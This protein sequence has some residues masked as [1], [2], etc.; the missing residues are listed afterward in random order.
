MDTKT[1]QILIDKFRLNGFVEGIDFVTDTR[2]IIKSLKM[3]FYFQAQK[4]A[5]NINEIS[6]YAGKHKNFSL[7]QTI[8]CE[9]IGIRLIQVWDSC[10]SDLD[11]LFHVLRVVLRE[12]PQPNKYKLKSES[13]S[14][15][16]NSSQ[17]N[18]FTEEGWSLVRVSEPEF[19]WVTDGKITE[20]RQMGSRKL[21]DCGDLH[22]ILKKKGSMSRESSQ[23]VLDMRYRL[24]QWDAATRGLSQP[25]ETYDITMTQPTSGSFLT[26]TYYHDMT[27]STTSFYSVGMSQEQFNDA[28][29]TLISVTLIS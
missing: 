13:L 25:A 14:R 16:W 17:K 22:Y 29:A 11:R 21:Y 19:V 18:Y 3:D 6:I 1:Q 15:M 5:I 10:F 26:Y 23:R 27:K 7:N 8:K 28:C 4:I 20:T 2:K 24:R 12:I 9:K